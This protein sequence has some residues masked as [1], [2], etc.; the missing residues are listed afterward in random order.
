MPARAATTSSPPPANRAESPP[1][2]EELDPAEVA[3]R[4][5]LPVTRLAR[6]LRQQDASGLGPT[7]TTAL[8][9][10]GRD[11]PITLTEL[12]HSERVAAA[13]MSR[14]V[15]K[16]EERA[17]VRRD[18][19]AGDG[20]SFRLSLTDAGRAQLAAN[21]SRRQAWL[22]RQVAGLSAEELARLDAAVA[23]LD[24]LTGSAR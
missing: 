2:A 14:A 20:R 18:G 1:V 22:S 4:L 7:L 9:T 3:D 6:L 13:T 21:R 5:R 23:V 15:A 8:S 11:G 17:L 19:V 24:K 10:I 16:L 12:A